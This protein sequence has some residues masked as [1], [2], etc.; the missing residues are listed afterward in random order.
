MRDLFMTKKTRGEMVGLFLALLELVRNG[1]VK[2]RQDKG[3]EAILLRMAPAE[4]AA[5]ATNVVAGEQA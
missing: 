4:D 1:K 5:A 2:V 3:N